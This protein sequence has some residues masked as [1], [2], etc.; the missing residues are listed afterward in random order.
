MALI[1]AGL[2]LTCLG[3]FG[4]LWLAGGVLRPGWRGTLGALA[5]QLSGLCFVYGLARGEPLGAV[6]MAAFPPLAMVPSLTFGRFGAFLTDLAWQVAPY[7]GV[8]LLVSL[9]LRTLRLWSLGLTLMTALLGA[10]SLG[11]GISQS[12]MCA[13]A[14]KRG[15]HSFDRNAFGWSMANSHQDI[16]VELHAA[17]RS[18]GQPLG[19]SYATLDW[20]PIPGSVKGFSAGAPFTCP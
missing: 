7:A 10:L 17:I 6:L 15:V 11:D 1:L 20:Y 18:R 2:V 5:L 9:T 12:A 13:A 19:W 3:I 14:A 8:A 16:Q 4:W